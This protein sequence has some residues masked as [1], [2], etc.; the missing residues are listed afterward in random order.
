VV[1]FIY[2]QQLFGRVQAVVSVSDSL[3]GSNTVQAWRDLP[4]QARAREASR[5]LRTLERG[6]LQLARALERSNESVSPSPTVCD[7]TS[8]IGIVTQFASAGNEASMPI[9][10]H[11]PYCLHSSVK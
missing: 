10:R 3:L 5:M 6:T 9:I 1:N 7:V 4:T 2:E 8:N 11:H